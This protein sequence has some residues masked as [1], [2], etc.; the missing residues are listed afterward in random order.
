M[1]AHATMG[2]VPVKVSVVVPVY[3]P[4]D[5]IEALID[6]LLN[7]SLPAEE[8][9]AVFVDDG[10]TDNTPALLDRA[11]AE[12][13]NLRVIHQ[14]NS[15]WPGKPRNVGI[16]NAQGDYVF[17]GDHDDWLG[18]EALER[19]HACAVRNNADIVIGK[20]V[21]H[22]R[23]ELPRELFRRNRDHA[24]LQNAPLQDS[25]TPHKLFRRAFLNEHGIRFPE[26]KRRLE[27]HVF[28]MTAYFAAANI[29]VISDYDFY[30]H[31]GRPD[32]GNAGRRAIEPVSYYGY[33]RETIAIVLANTEPGTLRD[34]VLRRFLR[35]EVLG[36]LAGRR[37]TDLS[38][39]QQRV[40]FDAAQALVVETM[41]TA[42]D[43][44]LPGRQR[45]VAGLLRAGDF[46]GVRRQAEWTIYADGR[47]R[48]IEWDGS[49][50]QVHWAAHAGEPR[51]LRRS[52]DR[53]MLAA[54]DKLRQ[55][56]LV[57][58]TRDVSAVKCD[59]IARD[60]ARGEVILPGTAQ[61]GVDGLGR[62]RLT[63]TASVRFG[64]RVDQLSD[65]FWTLRVRVRAL[66]WVADTGPFRWPAGR[67]PAAGVIPGPTLIRPARTKR[68]A[69]A[70][71]VG[72]RGSWLD[73]ALA[74]GTSYD[75]ANDQLTLGLPVSLRG[76]TSLPIFVGTK[77]YDVEASPAGTTQTA[78]VLQPGQPAE[79]AELS[80]GGVLKRDPVP[81]G[82]TLTHQ[83]GRIVIRR[84][85]ATKARLVR[86]RL[87]TQA[88]Y[89][90]TPAVSVV[91]RARRRIVRRIR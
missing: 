89:A 51:L 6:S 58:V 74:L 12:H 15:G 76:V 11:A 34:R 3:N 84:P 33:V 47:A 16:D 81:L 77:R 7:Q 88:S 57:D 25:L 75:V 46:E 23:G 55:H 67:R 65:G 73:S 83:D 69:L 85:V 90:V 78:V 71:D 29:S 48:R 2:H 42:V 64:D 14:P 66:G 82:L 27:D 18:A 61:V 91:D 26:G 43:E 86:Q 13:A 35:V 63:G 70:L 62:L 28:V 87:R 10:S 38:R 39:E 54:P 40:L 32:D 59:V 20:M 52:G 56:K 4:G 36:R 72:G 22:D 17:F 8:Y 31:I 24:T 30:H 5:H 53:I 50:F 60:L 41:P 44:G 37:F 9:E 79:P 19:L 68:G 80:L 45:L 21:A 49:A 1:T